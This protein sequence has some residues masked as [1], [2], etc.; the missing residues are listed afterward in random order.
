MPGANTVAQLVVEVNADTSAAEKGLTDLG[1]K[2]GSA[3]SALQTAF[4]GAAVAGIAGVAAGLTA[5]V[6]AA[7]DFEK[8]MSALPPSLARRPPR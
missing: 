8:T 3:G 2:V 4:A 6:V 5:S 7:T 1:T